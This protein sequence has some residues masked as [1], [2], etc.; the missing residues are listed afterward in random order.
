MEAWP[1]LALVDN[2]AGTKTKTK[3]IKTTPPP[4][5]LTAV[6]NLSFQEGMMPLFTDQFSQGT[7]V[8]GNCIIPH[9]ITNHKAILSYLISQNV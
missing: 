5:I 3:N 1:D 7:M 4:P 9:F 2:P 6:V 8:A